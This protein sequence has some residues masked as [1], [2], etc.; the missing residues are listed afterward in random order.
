MQPLNLPPYT[1]IK[2]RKS[3]AGRLTVLDILR[4]RY[5]TLT[6]E[7]WVRQHFV[8][9]LTQYLGY[10]ASL[11]A[12]EME[13][14]V[15]EKK[16]R[17]DSVLFDAD[18]HPRMI[19]EYKAPEIVLTEKVVQ[20]I[21]AYNTQLGVRYLVMSNGLQHIVMYFGDDGQWQ[22]LPEIPRYEVLRL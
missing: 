9:Y 7:E 21:M 18:Q 15:G 20:Q 4:R 1:D 11:M 14:R 5:V 22:Y 10:P 3:A 8:N 19:I 17:C 6:P 2:L 12:N 13:L 16:L